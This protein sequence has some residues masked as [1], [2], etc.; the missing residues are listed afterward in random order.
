MKDDIK[1]LDG[2][3]DNVTTIEAAP[4]VVFRAADGKLIAEP[5]AGGRLHPRH[6]TAN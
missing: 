4:G 6:E 1:I 5:E 3:V 2:H